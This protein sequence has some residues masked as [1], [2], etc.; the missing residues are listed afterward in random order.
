MI[1]GIKQYY[2]DLLI[3]VFAEEAN[4][5]KVI[6]YGSRAKGNYKDGSDIDLTIVGSGLSLEWLLGVE[7]R[8]DDLLMPYKVDLSIY[9]YIENEDLKNHIQRV[10]EV[11]YE[12]K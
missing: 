1:P 6:L 3:K 4:I 12:T 9:D 2:N 5:N 11:I 8:V 7:L 10:G